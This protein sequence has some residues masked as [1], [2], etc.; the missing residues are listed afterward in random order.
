MPLTFFWQQIPNPLVSELLCQ[1]G[2]DGVVLDLEHGSMNPETIY[3]CIQVITLKNKICLC[4]LTHLDKTLVRMCLDAGAT[5]LI[6]STVETEEYAE[7][8]CSYCLYPADKGKRGL[9]L[10]RENNFGKSDLA[11]R[12]PILIAQIET[13]KG[14][15]QAHKLNYYP[16]DFFLIGPYDLS[17]DLGLAGQIRHEEVQSCVSI[18]ESCVGKEKMGYHLVKGDLEA[19][20]SRLSQHGILAFSLDTLMLQAGVGTISRISQV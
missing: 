9:G 11:A 18:V 3:H 13:K 12:R 6:F 7:E 5:G 1:G 10:V 15:S 16:F 17:L 4:R 8:I 20:A 2:L 19:E 14:V